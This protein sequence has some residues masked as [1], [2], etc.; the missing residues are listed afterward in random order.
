METLR[1]L[2]FSPGKMTADYVSGKRQPYMNPIKFY[3]ACSLFFLFC[4]S[5][6]PGMEILISRTGLSILTVDHPEFL[7]TSELGILGLD[8]LFSTLSD[9]H[10]VLGNASV[11]LLLTVPLTASLLKLLRFPGPL[12]HHLVFSFHF[13]S[14]GLLILLPGLIP[15]KNHFCHDVFNTILSVTTL[16]FLGFMLK[17]AYSLPVRK[18]LFV[19]P[20]FFL[21]YTAAFILLALL[22]VLALG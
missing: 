4:F 1:V 16:V 7:I 22:R 10:E 6:V 15:W 11:F 2:F 9:R 19:L 13:H 12:V 3:F 20:V 21:F 5:R 18:V 17:R 8:S 14:L